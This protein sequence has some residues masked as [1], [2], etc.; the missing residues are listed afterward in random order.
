MEVNPLV[1]DFSGI[2]RVQFVEGT[3]PFNGGY[4][5]VACDEFSWDLQVVCEP[6]SN[7]VDAVEC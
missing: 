2:L 5:F 4:S 3:E 1:N 7:R 6:F